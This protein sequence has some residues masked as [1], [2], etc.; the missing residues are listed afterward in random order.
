MSSNDNAQAL[1]DVPNDLRV[2]LSESLGVSPAE[3]TRAAGGDGTIAYQFRQLLSMVPN[4]DDPEAFELALARNFTSLED[5][6]GFTRWV[7][8]PGGIPATIDIGELT[9]GQGTFYLFVHGLIEECHELLAR[10]EPMVEDTA[11]AKAADDAIA[12]VDSLLA[13]FDAGAA[14]PGG[15]FGILLDEIVMQLYGRNGPTTRDPSKIAGGVLEDLASRLYMKE[16]F[17]GDLADEANYTRFLSVLRNVEAICSAWTDG[18][19]ELAGTS[20]KSYFGPALYRLRLVLDTISTNVDDVF[21]QLDAVGID[22]ADR[23]LLRQPYGGVSVCFQDFMDDTKD[24]ASRVARN[25]I[26]TAGKLGAVALYPQLRARALTLTGT[27]VKPDD[28]PPLYYTPLVGAVVASLARSLYVATDIV[29]ELGAEPSIEQVTPYPGGLPRTEWGEPPKLPKPTPRPRA[30][31]HV[32]ISP[33]F[34]TVI[35]IE[36]DRFGEKDLVEIYP[37]LDPKK[38]VKA[39]PYAPGETGYQYK[40]DVTKL[41]KPQTPTK[42]SVRWRQTT[43]D[44]WQ[45]IGT[46]YELHP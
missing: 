14:T 21:R 45:V 6:D 3:P 4:R 11:S 43:K 32:T 41:P 28:F 2:V 12:V 35:I 44:P 1:V 46:P 31:S 37:T 7:Y 16:D 10:L 8:G 22:V 17:I 27:F 20:G 5:S 15:P 34:S 40:V 26:D 36:S 38:P 18:K 19:D 13:Q 29:N 33:T 30:V 42:Y 24:Y 9:G 25:L 23:R 39:V